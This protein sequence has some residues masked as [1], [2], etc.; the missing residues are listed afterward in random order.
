VSAGTCFCGRELADA[1]ERGTCCQ[2]VCQSDERC[3]K[4][5]LY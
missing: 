1:G 4:Q 2:G 5:A 3:V